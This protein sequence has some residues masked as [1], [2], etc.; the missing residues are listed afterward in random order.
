M[1][2]LPASRS[3]FKLFLLVTPS[4]TDVNSLPSKT[5]R[6]TTRCG[7]IQIGVKAIVVITNFRGEEPI[8]FVRQVHTSEKVVV[9]EIRSNI[10]IVRRV[11]I[12]TNKAS[13]QTMTNSAEDPMI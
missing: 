1:I 5:A 10:A 11:L 6:D 7:A 2:I 13:D 3:N 4:N 8:V 12:L 9:T